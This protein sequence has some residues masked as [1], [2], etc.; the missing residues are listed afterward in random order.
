MLHEVN[1]ICTTDADLD[2]L[3]AN[4][5][6]RYILEMRGFKNNSI[7]RSRLEVFSKCAVS[8]DA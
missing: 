8:D 4:L 3:F 1:V 2:S 6:Q 5:P 7:C